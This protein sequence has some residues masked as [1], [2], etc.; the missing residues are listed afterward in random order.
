MPS[1]EP[2][3][4]LVIRGGTIHDGTGAVPF[5]GDVAIFYSLF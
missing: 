1:Q 2:I 5:V 4:D 3:H